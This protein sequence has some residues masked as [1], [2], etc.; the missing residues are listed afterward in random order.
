MKKTFKGYQLTRPE[1]FPADPQRVMEQYFYNFSL[2]DVQDYLNELLMHYL[3]TDNA[4]PQSARNRSDAIFFCEQS[5]FLLQAVKFCV[6]N[7]TQS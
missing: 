4:A 6:E 1:D 2:Q 5:W 3:T 7:R